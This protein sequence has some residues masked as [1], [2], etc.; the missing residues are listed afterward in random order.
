MTSASPSTRP[1]ALF[2]SYNALI[3][4]LGPSQI[5]PYVCGLADR[6]DMTVLSFEKAVRTP[7]EDAQSTTNTEAL[8]RAHGVEWIRLTYHKRPSVP[9]T[10]YDIASG[11]R[12]IVRE[13]RRRPI[14]LVHARGYVPGAIALGV[15]RRTGIPFLFDIRGLQAEEYADAGHWDPKG[16]PFRLTKRVEQSILRAA[17]GIVT[18]TEAIRPIL[19]TFPGLRAR[20]ALPPW[21]VI[22][23][24][25]ELNHFR[26]DAAGRAR[27]RAAL[28][29]GDRPVIV[30]SGS[31]GTWYLLDEMVSFYQAARERWP[32]LF[33]LGLVNRAP[34]QVVQ[35]LKARGIPETDFAV[36]WATHAE[37]PAYLSA[38]DAG[39]AFIRPCLSKLSSSPT[40]Y[41]EY[42]ATGL[43]LVANAGVGDV[44]AI[45][46]DTGAGGLV[47]EHSPEAHARAADE[48]RR[49]ATPENR[50][51]WREVAEQRFSTAN[52]ALPA[53]RSLYETILARRPRRRGL[54]LTPYPLHSAPSQRLKFEQ[55]YSAFEDAGIE[56]VVSPF[57]TPALWRVLYKPGFVLTKLFYGAMGHLRRV[58][59]FA[60]AGRFDF[61]YVHLWALPFG[62]PW[63][64]EL[65]AKRGITIIYNIDDLIYL[66]R[67]SAANQFVRAL[68]RQDRIGRI[69][70]AASRVIVCTT[71]LKTFAE[72]H[73]RHVTLISSTI[74]T[75]AYQPRS[76]DAR[77]GPI[78]IGWSGSHSTAPYLHALGPVFRRLRERFDI[79]VLVIGTEQ[80]AIDG[81]PVE[82]R[83]WSLDREVTDLR[84]MDIGVYPLPD[85]EWVLGKSGLKALQY[86]GVGVPVVASRIGS[87]CEFIRHGVN[88]FLAGTDDEWVKSLTALIESPALRATVG[89]VDERYSVRVTAPVYLQVTS[90]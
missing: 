52:T 65:L 9:A 17:D 74:D 58:R 75:D 5:I 55:Y 18:L 68:R 53:Y 80:F 30:Y 79:R 2:V 31:I 60:R 16:F 64:E 67:A 77:T 47:S 15:K 42:L 82:A 35:A 19:R 33:F 46:R 10:I 21:R 49:L 83:A 61:V 62:P 57:V 22:P 81:V 71:H 50:A 51:R 27:V 44:D 73:N 7:E 69:M 89:A 34:E 56:V 6:Y 24:C 76:H 41:A 37:V 32:G 1:R 59:D 25:V 28:G 78:T 86:M 85:E 20:P 39:L 4:P 8:L 14:A 84:S 3:E 40:K 90:L 26:F 13:H 36:T 88:G 38:A 45:I 70:Q 48:I 54:F 87:A 63:F 29:I 11:V 23:S 43:P 72:K 66:P 12:R